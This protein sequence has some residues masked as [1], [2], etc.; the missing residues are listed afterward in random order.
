MNTN[1]GG[2][3]NID[4]LSVGA[5]YIN[6]QRFRDIVSSL[7]AEDTLEQ[8]ELD[9]LRTLLA[10]LKTDGLT[11]EWIVNNENKNAV[12][13]TLITALETKL[14]KIDTT[15]LTETSVLN[16]DNR[17]SVLKTRLDTAATDITGL[18]TRV[19]TAENDIDSL[20]TRATTDETNIAAIKKI[21][22]HFS[23]S[24]ANPNATEPNNRHLLI[25]SMKNINPVNRAG[26]DVTDPK[27]LL[28]ITAGGTLSGGLYMGYDPES[29]G[30]GDDMRLYTYTGSLLLQAKT[31]VRLT[32]TDDI[33]IGLVKD[34]LN[35]YQPHH[36]NIGGAMSRINI[37]S[38]ETPK[39]GLTPFD[40]DTGETTEIR[41]GKNTT[42]KNTKTWLA[43]NFYTS[44]SRW[45]D[46]HVTDVV[47]F[48]TAASWLAGF[49]FS[50][51]V[52]YWLAWMALSG[53]P[54]YRY[55]DIVKM[56]NNYYTGGLTK[57][58]AIET[59]NDISVK[60]MRVI[61]FTVVSLSTAFD[62]ILARLVFQAFAVH[63][64]H[65]IGSVWGRTNIYAGSGEIEIRVDGG[66]FE[67]AFK[68][69]G[70]C[71]RVFLDNNHV[72]VVQCNG[73]D[74]S[75]RLRLVA[76]NGNIE[77]ST[78]TGG[79]RANAK[80]IMEI[81]SNKQIVIGSDTTMTDDTYKMLIDTTSHT[82]GIKVAKGSDALLLNPDNVNSKSLTIQ[83]GYTG[84]TV[85]T[86]FM[87]S[88]NKLMWNGTVLGSGGGGG[89]GL[90]YYIPLTANVTNPAP[91]PTTQ[92]ATETYTSANQR[93][94]TQSTTA[95]NT[96][97]LMAKYATGIIN[98]ESNPFVEGL[99]TIQQHL[100]WN[101]NNIV[102]QIY[103]Q[104]WFQALASGAGAFIYDRS[105]TGVTITGGYQV[106][107]GVPILAPQ[108]LFNLTFQSV[109]FPGIKVDT[110]NNASI[111][112]KCRLEARDLI[113]ENWN[114]LQTSTSSITY[115]LDNQENQ[116]IT[117]TETFTH[118][119]T[120]KTNAPTAYR[121]VLFLTTPQ[122]NGQI[123]Q[124]TF[125]GSTVNDLIAYKL[126]ST[127]GNTAEIRVLLYDGV[128]AKKTIPHTSTPILNPIELPISL[129]YQ[130]G[131]FNNGRLGFDIYMFQPSGVVNA[132][133]QMTFYFGDGTISHI[134]TTI[135][136]PPA[137]TPTL[138]Q[139]LNSGATASHPINMNTNKISG[140]TT[141]EGS[142]NGNWEV[143]EITA[144]TNI[145]RSVTT[146]NYT[147]NN[148][149][150]V[151]D[152]TAGTNIG[153]IITSNA[154]TI[155]NTAP[156]QNVAA[157][158]GI[159]VSIDQNTKIATITNTNVGA[160][161]VAVSQS[162]RDE[163]QALVEVGALPR[164][165]DYWASNW[166]VADSVVNAHN[167][168]YVSV[169][170]KVIC[171]AGN[172]SLRYSTNYGSTWFSG[173]F[174]TGNINFISVCGNSQGS[175]LFAFGKN[176][177]QGG[178]ESLVLYT[179]VGNDSTSVPA[180]ANWTQVTSSAF[181]G[182]TIA[183]RLR[184]SG[185]G[186]Y[187]L[188]SSENSTSAG[189]RA[190]ISSNSGATWA[191]KQIDNNSSIVGATFGVCISRSGATQYIIWDGTSNFTLSRI[192]RSLDYGVTW[193]LVS[194]QVVDDLA[195]NMQWDRIECDA[196]G[197]FVM[198]T[199]ISNNNSEFPRMA[200]SEDYGSNWL[201]VGGS[202]VLDLWVSG[203]GQFFAGIVKPYQGGSLVI[204][205]NDYGR[206][207]NFAT[208]G[209]GI[210]Y[211]CF[212]GSA[213][214]SIL[215]MASR[216]SVGDGLIRITRSGVVNIYDNLLAD[217]L[218]WYSSNLTFTNG[219]TM[220][221][222][223]NATYG[224]IDLDLYNIEYEI[225][226][227]WDRT[228]TSGGYPSAHLAMG[229]NTIMNDPNINSSNTVWNFRVE[230]VS[231]LNDYPQNYNNRFYCGYA[232]GGRNGDNIRYKTFL[233]GNL[234]VQK[235]R[236]SQ[237]S[238]LGSYGSDWSLNARTLTNV[239]NSVQYLI[240]AE[241]TAN[242][243]QERSRLYTGTDFNDGQQTTS[244]TAIW[245][246]TSSDYWNSGYNGAGMSGG[247][248]SIQVVTTD[249]SNF[250]GLARTSNV[251]SRFWRVKK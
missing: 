128:N 160:T 46:L 39:V 189:V 55:S 68:N 116:T 40:S 251:S 224:A 208:S 200:R 165:P 42:F 85:N 11:S 173:A 163:H 52:P 33:N 183:P 247:I 4:V 86:L 195:L 82:N 102:G 237:T 221:F 147:I 108:S 114:I 185:D 170:G 210:V 220:L 172:N 94:I 166:S 207:Y 106:L 250:A 10:N 71:N 161:Q 127:V 140:I 9:L 19:T 75:G 87:N 22:N 88:D 135:N 95:V 154:A 80:K 78:A 198:A 168:I 144:G 56:A 197:R 67:W 16:N 192:Y 245:E 109:T 76:A 12:L 244:G 152:V 234:N 159:S 239:F 174:G 242:S 25:L 246:L 24:A 36:I 62:A 162:F 70:N 214:G 17:N 49:V 201:M 190:L 105:F 148:T 143:K 126:G 58:H 66:A 213:D 28:V 69:A 178:A 186:T 91:S 92:V 53:T 196:T 38:V 215:V 54:N 225:E 206:S 141:L 79:V 230:Q 115:T 179:S 47:T 131:A 59:S 84:S 132:G 50:G 35:G 167:D 27:K 176:I 3:T 184:C 157:G 61:D 13:K 217:R 187:L 235:R 112:M 31:N 249:N 240:V 130:I 171:V 120:S 63:G 124:Q 227:N 233:T 164:K 229:L 44:E 158:T 155:S 41:I 81:K 101:Q 125:A 117:F 145:G 238:N 8:A 205:S 134:E 156:V 73:N 97:I 90:E 137:P 48:E 142:S 45:E 169:D 98:K 32:A 223:I 20:E 180:G 236:V 77:L 107:N 26:D 181:T 7:I 6:G 146:G 212:G 34:P 118:N 113:T 89:G 99:Q 204:N 110:F 222:P 150:P 136:E 149:A 122:A 65:S 219:A 72:E 93:T 96:G 226:I 218:L 194:N 104:T 139:V 209:T 119:Q 182:L 138:A 30:G 123:H 216:T 83:S 43:G 14:A 228:P 60:N 129:P 231:G 121:M 177:A 103:G 151:Q 241:N 191:V 51:G 21:T 64:S 23:Y 1:N 203:T 199:R 153:V 211:S 248:S 202:G 188:A 15:A 133:H 100:T 2:I 18:T 193:L 5:L 232:S 175:K 29:D 74:G 57:N 243:G 37:G 111:T